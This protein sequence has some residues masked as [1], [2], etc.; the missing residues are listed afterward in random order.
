MARSHAVQTSFLSGVLDPRASARV[1]TDAFAQGLLVGKNITPVHL[2][3]VRRRPGLKYHAVLP[4]QL[5]RIASGITPTAPQGGTAANA[6]D[7][8]ATTLTTTTNNVSTTNPYVVVQYDLGSA[9]AVL[10]AD[11]LDISSTGG[12]STQFCVQYSSDA[13]SWT[14]LGAAFET[15]DSLD[16][17]T[18]RRVGPVTAR[19]W[20]VAKIGGTDMGAVHIS[21]SGFNL[22]QDS[23]DVSEGRAIAF[24]VST[25]ERYEVVLT[26]RSATIFYDD[27]ANGWQLQD[28]QPMPYLSADLADIDAKSDVFTM[29]LVHEDY[30][31]RFLVRETTTN[32]QSFN[33][34]FDAVPQIDFADATSPSPTSDVQTVTFASGWTA[35]DTFQVELEGAKTAAITF[36][37]DNSTTA[38]NIAR[39]V[40]KLWTVQGFSGV[41]CARTGAL[42]FAITLAA[43]SADTYDLMAVIALSSSAAATVVHTTTGSP[44][45]E[46]VWSATRG[47]PRTVDFFEG[48][49]YFGGTRAR[50]NVMIAS[51]VNDI[52]NLEIGEGLD[53]DAIFTTLNSVTAIQGIFSGRSLQVFGTNGEYRYVKDQ[54]AAIVPGDA[55]VNQ[56]QYGSAKIRPVSIDGA[57][58]YVQR[59]RKS[60]RDFRFD[61]TENAY[62]SLGVSSLA[63]HLIYDVRDIAAWNGS[64]I[65]EI[66]LVFVVNGSNPERTRDA[67]E[68]DA[69]Y[70]DAANELVWR[71]GTVAVFNSRKEANVQA[72]TIWETLGEFK[73]VSTILQDIFFLVKRSLNGVDVLTFEQAVDDYYTDCAIK[74][75]NSPAPRGNWS[76]VL[77]GEECRVKADGFVLQN[78]T[79]SGGG[80][81]IQLASEDIEIGLDWDV[82]ITPMPCRPFRSSG[83]TFCV[84][85]A[86]SA[87]ARKSASL[88]ACTATVSHFLTASSNSTTSM[89]RRCHSP[90]CTRLPTARTGI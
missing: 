64:A 15:V 4:N 79:P 67:D 38:A 23:G 90:E 40:Q 7:N 50:Q 6:N 14:T 66:G 39:E 88:S 28:R 12:S 86:S 68:P 77:N 35:G 2:G 17:R 61:Y 47:Y 63:P 56:T 1:E 59:N 60:I 57:T 26:D 62:N 20:R 18:Y 82:A 8:S 70:T 80:A 5:T 51:V 44:R 13:S 87:S 46:P 27:P 25:S 34:D 10:F 37:G 75:T 76:C 52:L 84:S 72:W 21:I 9:K 19:Y 58:I 74:V 78:V 71:D 22:W 48:R 83:R 45:R 33:V 3:G 89:S 11:V 65:D 81:T 43:A 49:A 24:E 85:A 29:A 41:T 31:P 36:A 54:G 30:P 55:P 53:D 16:T 32:L 42:T 73:A 69:T